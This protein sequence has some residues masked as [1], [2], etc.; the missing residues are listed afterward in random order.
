MATIVEI[1]KPPIFEN[2]VFKDSSLY[3]KN[4]I[5]FMLVPLSYDGA[6]G[7]NLND[8]REDPNV[9][10]LRIYPKEPPVI[11]YTVGNSLDENLMSSFFGLLQ[12]VGAAARSMAPG[13]DISSKVEELIGGIPFIGSGAA[14]LTKA[15]EGYG[16]AL[17]KV[18][19]QTE[20]NISMR[21]EVE[22]HLWAWGSKAPE[23]FKQI[24][25]T[26]KHY[27]APRLS[28]PKY[29]QNE[30]QGQ[31]TVATTNQETQGFDPS[32]L[33]YTQPYFCK[34]VNGKNQN[35]VILN[36]A[37]VSNANINI[38]T[39]DVQSVIVNGE[40]K[41]SYPRVL[42]VELEF[43]PLHFTLVADPENKLQN[44]NLMSYEKLI[45]GWIL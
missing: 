37:I 44:K 23:R 25:S 11:S 7:Y 15:L 30:P 45:E 41:G 40:V 16:V 6:F 35:K 10:R 32:D 36:A 8:L 2:D 26:L 34:L 9:P 18:W 3:E 19:T 14:A 29:G 4:F 27:I 13:S 38:D 24:M 39:K 42:R 28:K 20:W 22:E 17:P 43:T 21:L 12:S 1:G 5:S 31:G 33:F